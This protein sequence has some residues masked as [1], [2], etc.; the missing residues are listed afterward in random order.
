MSPEER[1]ETNVDTLVIE[2]LIVF[3]ECDSQYNNKCTVL[4]IGY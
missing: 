1:Q 3:Q 4:V 2:L